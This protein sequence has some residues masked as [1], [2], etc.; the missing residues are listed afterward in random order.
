MLPDLWSIGLCFLALADVVEGMTVAVRFSPTTAATYLRETE[1]IWASR[2]I[3]GA[4]MTL[5][6]AGVDSMSL[7]AQ[8]TRRDSAS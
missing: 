2:L 4:Q 1:G 7:P 6:W 5:G 3:R 8:L